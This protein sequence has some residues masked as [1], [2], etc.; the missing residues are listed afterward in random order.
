MA[1]GPNPPTRTPQTEFR[2]LVVSA[3]SLQLLM[4]Y[5]LRVCLKLRVS[6]VVQ[7]SFHQVKSC[8]FHLKKPETQIVD[9][10]LKIDRL[11]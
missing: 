2:D 1:V 10:E 6:D 8:D 11:T 4:H 5:F 3:F 9:R 7:L